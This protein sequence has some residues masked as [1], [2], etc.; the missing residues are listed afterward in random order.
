MLTTTFNIVVF[1]KKGIYW[2]VSEPC[3]HALRRAG[4]QVRYSW[5]VLCPDSINL[6]FGAHLAPLDVFAEFNGRA[7]IYNLE[8]AGADVKWFTAAYL[9]ILKR[10]AV[11]DY[12]AQNIITLKRYGIFNAQHVPL[13]Y[14]PEMSMIRPAPVQDID[15]LFYGVV[16]DRR[17]EVLRK[18][19]QLGMS[20]YTTDCGDKVLL[21][22]ARDEY[23]ARAK[24]VLNMHY[25]ADTQIFEIVRVSYLLSNR[26]AVVAE[27][28][29]N[30]EIDAEL[31]DAV[32]GGTLEQLPEL[33]QR[34]VQDD[35]L[36][37]RLEQRGFAAFSRRNHEEFVARALA[38]RADWGPIAPAEH[39][40]SAI[41]LPET[42][43]INHWRSDCLNLSADE[44]ADL[45]YALD[46][47]L[48]GDGTQL[49]SW[50]FGRFALEK[51]QFNKITVREV[52]ERVADLHATLAELL[53]W[54]SP[55]GVLEI[56]APYDLSSGAWA[57]GANRR[58]FNERSW[59]G[60]IE[61][62]NLA[63][64]QGERLVIVSH[65]WGIANEFGLK[66]LQAMDGDWE[67]TARVPRA[68]DAL[69]VRLKRVA[70]H[71]ESQR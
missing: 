39:D 54:L 13:G 46:R 1:G 51:Y 31:V 34:L 45:H 33:C 52:F 30:T 55:D 32:A 53:A 26:K 63:C 37:H 44:D 17:A 16:N 38:Q 57:H 15:V 56:E 47:P 6:V 14:V 21:G 48:F 71:V 3:A 24:V 70:S 20:V 43:S 27:I 29:E 40:T 11:W 25:Y 41:P 60:I 69:G 49:S 62:Y 7:V 10:F 68:V 5:D 28:G 4:H 42:L 65:G 35:V 64:E 2:E 58:A 9:R 59:A 23:I 19:E 8:Q 22:S 50:R 66:T 18:I 67:A 36:R 61:A 12:S